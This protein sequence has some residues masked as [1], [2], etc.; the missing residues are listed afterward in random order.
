[1][2][3][4][5]KLLRIKHSWDLTEKMHETLFS[6]ALRRQESVSLSIPTL[7]LPLSLTLSQTASLS[8]PPQ[9][10]FVCNPLQL[11]VRT[12]LQKSH[13]TVGEKMILQVYSEKGTTLGL[14]LV[15][16]GFPLSF[17]H[18]RR[19]PGQVFIQILE[20]AQKNGLLFFQNVRKGN[21][22]QIAL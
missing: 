22:S 1:M 12:A 9:P 8:I 21:N 11:L 5:A 6:P 18:I 10:T 20:I 15:F 13:H 19:F 3:R 7:K 16:V 4:W 2:D 17:D 14:N